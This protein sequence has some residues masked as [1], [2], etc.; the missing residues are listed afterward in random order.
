[1]KNFNSILVKSLLK[2]GFTI[3]EILEKKSEYIQDDYEYLTPVVVKKHNL[4]DVISVKDLLK[5]GCDEVEISENKTIYV[6]KDL[7]SLSK[8]VIDKYKLLD[9]VPFDGVVVQKLSGDEMENRWQY[10]IQGTLEIKHIM[11]IHPRYIIKNKDIIASKMSD[12]NTSRNYS[13]NS[14]R[15]RFVENFCID[16]SKLKGGYD[17][18]VGSSYSG[19]YNLDLTLYKLRFFMVGLN[20]LDYLELSKAFI[21][22]GIEDFDKIESFITMNGYDKQS[23]E[24]RFKFY[25]HIYKQPSYSTRVEFFEKLLKMGIDCK[26]EFKRYVDERTV[27]KHIWDKEDL[28]FIKKTFTEDDFEKVLLKQKESE[29]IKVVNN[30]SICASLNSSDK[31]RGVY[32]VENFY[33]DWNSYVQ[34][35]KIP[36]GRDADVWVG[37]IYIYAKLDKLNELSNVQFDWKYKDFIHNLAKALCGKWNYNSRLRIG[38]ELSES[39]IKKV[40]RFMM[41]YSLQIS[42]ISDSSQ[43][44]RAPNYQMQVLYYKFDKEEFKD[45]LNVCST[46]KDN[47]SRYNSRDGE[48]LYTLKVKNLTALFRVLKSDKDYKGVDYLI[49]EISKWKFTTDERKLTYDWLIDILGG[50]SNYTSDINNYKTNYKEVVDRYFKD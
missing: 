25:D 29:F 3:E 41:N 33:K 22:V 11:H 50:K 31:I 10:I 40:Y 14:E 6:S 19:D 20:D 37:L 44:H 32:T 13:N 28:E 1:V 16:K 23:N 35:S 34:V 18:R 15:N 12:H 9:K 30:V 24:D 38:L 2:I 17:Y 42:E 27:Y 36:S 43:T 47:A 45:Y 7:I 49:T 5:I 26:K 48:I 4:Y 8:S 21:D 46:I 39:Q